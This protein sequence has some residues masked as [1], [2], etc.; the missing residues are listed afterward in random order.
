M[1]SLVEFD[2]PYSLRHKLAICVSPKY[3]SGFASGL[4][5]GDIAMADDDRANASRAN[6]R[7]FVAAGAG[8]SAAVLAGLAAVDRLFA[9][10]YEVHRQPKKRLLE[11]GQTILFQGDSITDAGRDKKLQDEVNS[12]K[13][14]G[15]GYAWLAASQLLVSSP[16][17]GYKI[18]NR[19]I[20]GNKVYQLAERWQADCLD[21][22]PDLLS[23]LIGVNDYWHLKKH[24]YDGTVEKYETD[25]RALVKRTKDALP[26]VRLVICE[27][28]LLECGNVTPDWASE[29]APYRAA[30]RRVAEEAGATFVPFQSIIDIASKIAP[31]DVWA[32]D[33]VHPSPSGAALMAHAWLDAVGA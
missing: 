11:N 3:F 6:R 5:F 1:V 28:F 20:S 10:E 15:G 22:K 8:L 24:N 31:P 9:Q 4:E 33:G 29:F 25:Y 12:Y 21:I 2:P 16:T 26:N 13:A 17:A 30:A 27:P 19:G 18:F 14:L 7:E 23:I 32:K